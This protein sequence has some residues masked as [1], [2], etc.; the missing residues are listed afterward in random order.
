M[1]SDRGENALAA[2]GL[3]DPL[4]LF[5]DDFGLGVAAVAVV[6]V[7]RDGFAVELGQQDVGDS[8]MDVVRC[9]FENV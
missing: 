6:V 7:G 4:G 8:V 9:S 2:A 5:G 3:A 1:V